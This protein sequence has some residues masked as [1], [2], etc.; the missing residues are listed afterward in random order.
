M[1]MS[2]NTTSLFRLPVSRLLPCRCK[3]SGECV[4]L[5]ISGGPRVAQPTRSPTRARP[6]ARHTRATCTLLTHTGEEGGE[7]ARGREGCAR[8]R[9]CVHRRRCALVRRAAAADN[10]NT[11][12]WRKRDATY[13][14]WRRRGECTSYPWHLCSPTSPAPAPSM[15]PPSPSSRRRPLHCEHGTA[16]DE[17]HACTHDLTTLLFSRMPLPCADAAAL[18][19][20]GSYS[21]ARPR[22]G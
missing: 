22:H 19:V 8:E 14:E 21:L 10:R 6:H 2:I 16:T 15:S 9:D 17:P 11:T 18:L 3:T 7:G 12:W 20:S 5:R 4:R 13:A 1:Y